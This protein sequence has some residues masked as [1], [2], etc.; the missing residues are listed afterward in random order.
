M[1]DE[2]NLFSS[3]GEYNLPD[4]IRDMEKQ[5]L[6]IDLSRGGLMPLD[7]PEFIEIFGEPIDEDLHD[8]TQ[9][10]I[11]LYLKQGDDIYIPFIVDAYGV[12]WINKLLQY[13]ESIEEYEL[14]SILKEHLDIY[15]KVNDVKSNQRRT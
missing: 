15:N 5:M 11:K 13:N 3:D 6:K 9:S 14:C 4:R 2:D 7:I 12:D 10:Y 8:I 1:E